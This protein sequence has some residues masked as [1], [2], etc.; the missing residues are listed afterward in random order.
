MEGG[1]NAS[2][3]NKRGGMLDTAG[4]E[5][6][7]VPLHDSSILYLFIS[8]IVDNLKFSVVVQPVAQ[9]NRLA[10][11]AS[12]LGTISATPGKNTKE[13]RDKSQCKVIQIRSLF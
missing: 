2:F 1:N 12:L 13:S 8:F 11:W 9:L 4:K 10:D 7:N 3:P 6:P 5:C